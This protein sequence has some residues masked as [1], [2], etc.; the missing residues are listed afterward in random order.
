[1]SEFCDDWGA[2]DPA[3]ASEFR[4]LSF[5]GWGGVSFG[6]SLVDGGGNDGGGRDGGGMSKDPAIAGLGVI[7]NGE[8]CESILENKKYFIL[9]NYKSKIF[10][11]I[12]K[13]CKLKK[14]NLFKMKT[15]KNIILFKV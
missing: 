11:D 2:T 4:S 1:M 9:I 14:V 12:F 7:P 10:K 13:L 8:N 6:R 3:L 15:K 5:D